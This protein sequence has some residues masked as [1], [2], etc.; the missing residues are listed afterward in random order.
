[1]CGC[2]YTLGVCAAS[3]VQFILPKVCLEVTLWS[4]LGSQAGGV[5]L[6]LLCP[7]VVL[8]VALC[9][10]SRQGLQLCLVSNLH[11]GGEGM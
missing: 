8:D 5:V 9:Q 3:L 7:Q 2:G 1:M 4:W 11:R 10:S 6:R